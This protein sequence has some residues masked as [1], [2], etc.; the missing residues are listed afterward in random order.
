MS[1]PFLADV[2]LGKL[3]PVDEQGRQR[4]KKLDGKRVKVE[5]K[6]PRSGPHHRLFWALAT[7]VWQTLPENQQLRYP[8]V[9]SL[10]AALK[11]IAG[12]R[13]LIVFPDGSQGYIPKSISYDRMSQEEFAAFF[14]KCVDFICRTVLPG[15]A[16]ADLKREIEE[17][18][19]MRK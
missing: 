3:V 2:K 11:I 15:V 1:A 13:Q 7:T 12:H 10:V 6:V 9:E 8:D 4:L 14:E 19:G 5:A 16:R 18:V 17:M